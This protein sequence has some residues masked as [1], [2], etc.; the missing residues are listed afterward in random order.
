MR[1]GPNLPTCCRAVVVATALATLSACDPAGSDPSPSMDGDQ[2][3]PA[4]EGLLELGAFGSARNFFAYQPG[5]EEEIEMGLQGGFHIFVDGRL[6][7]EDAPSELVIQ[8]DVT[9]AEDGLEV[10]SIRH[11]RKPDL[12]DA[13]GWPTLPELIIFIPDPQLVEGTQVDVAVRVEALDGV[14]LDTVST[15]LALRLAQ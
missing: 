5:D 3:D 14:L 13:Q 6:R 12:A 2:A 10:T 4:T 11:Q 15:R 9:R 7:P 8:L 1:R